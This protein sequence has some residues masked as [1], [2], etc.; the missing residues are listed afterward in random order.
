V[1]FKNFIIGAA[2]MSGLIIGVIGIFLCLLVVIQVIENASTCIRVDFRSVLAILL[3]L[4]VILAPARLIYYCRQ[5]LKS[6]KVASGDRA[7]MVIIS[8]P[9]ST[10]VLGAIVVGLTALAGSDTPGSSGEFTYGCF[11]P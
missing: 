5:H 6:L 4:V 8:L 3:L 7:L 1:S 2:Y 10:I 11:T 9:V